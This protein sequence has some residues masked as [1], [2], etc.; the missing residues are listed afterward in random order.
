MADKLVPPAGT[1]GTRMLARAGLLGPQFVAAHGTCLDDDEIALLA[2][3]G[4]GVAHCPRSNALLGCGIA[5]LREL[6][7]AG[8]RVGLGTDSPASTPS[9]DMFEELRAS[10]GL[11]RFPLDPPWN[12]LPWAPHAPSG[13]T[14]RSA[15]LP[16]ASAQTSPSCR[17]QAHR[18]FR[19][20]IPRR[21][22]SSAA[23]RAAWLSQS[24]TEPSA[25]EGEPPN[26]PS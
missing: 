22:W 26:G 20:R 9:F 19:G 6:L 8:I 14:R 21:R 11:T 13:S 12:S 10:A 23:P 17:S 2:E 18:T 15:R 7:E 24:S 1:T 5:P 4:A 3:S 16:A 25:T